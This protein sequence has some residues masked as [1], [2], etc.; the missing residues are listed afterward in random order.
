M[1]HQAGLLALG[2][3]G[4]GQPS[5]RG[6]LS[7]PGSG[8]H[9][10]YLLR[11]RLQRRDRPGISPGSGLPRGFFFKHIQAGHRL[12]RENPKERPEAGPTNFSKCVLL[13]KSFLLLLD[14]L[15]L[16][17]ELLGIL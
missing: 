13:I 3:A 14:Y 2:S 16:L 6:Y 17:P 1:H 15:S 9:L 5:H 10:P 7:A 11:P 12:S 4:G 8:R